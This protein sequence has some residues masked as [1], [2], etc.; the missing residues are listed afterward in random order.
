M[1]S[2]SEQSIVLD[3]PVRAAYERWSRFE[4]LP[5]FMMDVDEVIMLGDGLMHWVATVC[6]VTL[7]WNARIVERVQDRRIA[8][9]SEGGRF[10]DG[11]VQL[12]PLGPQRTR[13]TVRLE[14]EPED[15]AR[16]LGD[17]IGREPAE[18]RA[19]LE[20]FKELVGDAHADSA[21]RAATS[22]N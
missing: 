18:L 8:W 20:C 12:E 9:Q 16:A 14:F 5:R 4:E 21:V 13:V 1:G 3:V 6:G 17:K 2:V 7:A 15:I 11:L 22:G 10:N 19:D